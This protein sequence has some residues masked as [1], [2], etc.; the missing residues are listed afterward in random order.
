M[1]FRCDGHIA[2]VKESEAIGWFKFFA[3]GRNARNSRTLCD[4]G[5]PCGRLAH[6]VGKSVLEIAREA[7]PH[8]T[9]SPRVDGYLPAAPSTIHETPP[10]T[11]TYKTSSQPR[12]QDGHE[13][14]VTSY[15]TQEDVD[16]TLML[17]ADAF[18]RARA[19]IA[20]P[21]LEDLLAGSI[22]KDE[23]ERRAG[24]PPEAADA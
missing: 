24:M 18:V 9:V 11:V 7:A 1:F 23:A 4:V 2:E 3:N 19:Q 22:A 15:A 5:Q 10:V 20:P 12:G 13:V 21:S 14:R 16:R 17:A 8:L 6:W